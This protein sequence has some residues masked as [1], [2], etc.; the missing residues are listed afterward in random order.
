MSESPK[1]QTLKSSQ[2]WLK[3]RPKALLSGLIS[4]GT[5]G[6]S[7]V[8]IG[9]HYLRYGKAHRNAGTLRGFEYSEAMKSAGGNWSD[10]DLN[11][12]IA[13]P[14]VVPGTSMPFGGL[15]EEK[16]RADIIS[17]LHVQTN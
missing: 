4:C 7:L 2:F 17:Y 11:G 10:D 12:F 14:A 8:T 5:C 15:A 1:S 3:R 16:D 9:K 6:S 13:H